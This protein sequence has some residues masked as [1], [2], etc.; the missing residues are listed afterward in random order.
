MELARPYNLGRKS[1]KTGEKQEGQVEG[2]YYAV[3]TPDY[4]LIQEKRTPEYLATHEK[5]RITLYS[6]FFCLGAETGETVEP[7]WVK[8]SKAID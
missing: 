4:S 6:M 8:N 7:E 3:V 5:V 1:P 2:T